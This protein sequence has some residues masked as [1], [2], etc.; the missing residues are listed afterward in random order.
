MRLRVSRTTAEETLAAAVNR[1][2]QIYEWVIAD[3][4]SRR[5]EGRFDPTLDNER[6]SR[7]FKEWGDSVCKLLNSIFPTELESN[8][9][10]HDLPYR[11]RYVDTKTTDPQWLDTR[12]T[13]LDLVRNLT[14]IME[15]SLPRYTDLPIGERLYIEHIDSFGKAKDV[16]PAEVDPWLIE[17]YL[18]MSEDAIQ[19]ALEQIID[20]PFHKKDWGGGQTISTLPTSR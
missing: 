18:E 16:N 10:A 5:N 8:T 7:A 6:Y 12:D 20:E 11:V 4:N 2:Y 19:I 17:G 1:G 3:Y 13:L 14:R 15:S 9:F